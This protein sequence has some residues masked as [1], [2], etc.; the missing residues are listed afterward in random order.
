MVVVVVVVAVDEV[1]VVA[2]VM[3]PDQ[4]IDLWRSAAERELQ[5]FQ[6]TLP[7]RLALEVIYDQN[8]FTSDRLGDLTFNLISALVIVF[9]VLV[10]SWPP[11]PA[12]G[13]P[14]LGRDEGPTFPG[15]L[16]QGLDGVLQF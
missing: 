1:V 8:A 15:H 2:A 11:G 12:G 3:E 6:R 9:A 10:S 16:P 5:A 14:I 4:R 7:P 13:G